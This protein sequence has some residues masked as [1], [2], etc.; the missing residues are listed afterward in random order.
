MEEGTG[1]SMFSRFRRDP[2]QGRSTA[3]DLSPDG[4]PQRR[5]GEASPSSD[6]DQRRGW[7]PVAA[8]LALAVACL[9]VLFALVAPDQISDLTV[10]AFVR[11]PV[12]GLLGVA[13]VVVLPT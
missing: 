1:M 7:R 5:P 12:E 9:L 10:W 8:R 2:A 11:I 6:A 13:L 3:T 4:D